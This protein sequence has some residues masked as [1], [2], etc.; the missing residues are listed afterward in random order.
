MHSPAIGKKTSGLMNL[1]IAPSV[2]IKKKHANVFNYIEKNF[3]WSIIKCI[4]YSS[5][6]MFSYFREMVIHDWF[7][8]TAIQKWY[9]ITLS[10]KLQCNVMAK[11]WFILYIQNRIKKRKE[12]KLTYQQF[13][14]GY[15]K[16]QVLQVDLKQPAIKI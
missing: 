13:V 11:Y 7:L 1:A 6:F 15:L 14:H 16:Y 9:Y 2:S 12:K 4:E 8:N 10:F 3:L 5:S